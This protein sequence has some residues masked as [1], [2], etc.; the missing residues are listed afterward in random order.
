MICFGLGVYQ[1]ELVED[2][3]RVTIILSLTRLKVHREYHSHVSK[4]PEGLKELTGM[5]H[6][7]LFLDLILSFL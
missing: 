7:H 6:K 4:K 3:I 5:S 2:H 1:M